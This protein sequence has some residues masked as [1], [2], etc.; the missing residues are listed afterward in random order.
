MDLKEGVT[1]SGHLLPLSLP[2]NWVGGEHAGS[3]KVPFL[4]SS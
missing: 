4:G 1:A 2:L 3:R